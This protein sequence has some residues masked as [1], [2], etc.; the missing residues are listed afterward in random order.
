MP[1]SGRTDFFWEYLKPY[2]GEWKGKSFLEIGAG[3]GW[4]LERARQAGARRAVGVEPAQNN[5][6]EALRL[7]PKANVVHNSFEGFDSKGERYDVIVGVMSF[8]HIADIAGAFKKIR[9]LLSESGEVILVI[10]DYEYFRMPRHDYQVETQEINADQYAVAVTR[11][12]GTIAD[13]IRR[14]SV[15]E[16]A[17]K[18]TGLA[19]VEDKAMK[20]TES[21]IAR[22][23]K[24]QSVRDHALTR[25]LRFKIKR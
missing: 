10:P 7:Y 2:A 25:L 1:D 22:S 19:L 8:P 14:V 5:I 20:P 16:A 15:Y 18:A 17:A 11:E 4:L 13:I 12:T 24:Y 23:P 6:V 9:S 21:Q 3:T